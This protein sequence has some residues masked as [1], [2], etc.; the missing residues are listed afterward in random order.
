MIIEAKT[1]KN[2]FKSVFTQMVRTYCLISGGIE[3]K[4][5]AEILKQHFLQKGTP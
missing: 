4:M 2:L 5:G 3:D 1:P